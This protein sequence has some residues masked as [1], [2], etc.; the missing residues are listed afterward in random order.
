MLKECFKRGFSIPTAVSK[1]VS[2]NVLKR[3]VVSTALAGAVLG[4]SFSALAQTVATPAG[5][6]IAPLKYRQSYPATPYGRLALYV[7]EHSFVA[8]PHKR[9]VIGSISDLDSA[10]LPDV[11]K[12]H[13]TYYRPDYLPRAQKVTPSEIQRFAARNLGSGEAGVVIVGDGREFLADLKNQFPH[14]QVIPV[15]KLDLNNAALVKP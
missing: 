13:E 6:N 8:H 10:A 4:F 5:L 1:R 7:D 3:L 9:G 2:V 12:F 15:D 14:V 11:R